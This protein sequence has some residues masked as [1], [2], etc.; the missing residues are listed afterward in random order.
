M[1]PGQRSRTD[2]V[3][4]MGDFGEQLAVLALKLPAL[5]VELGDRSLVH[6]CLS[7]ALHADRAA[8]DRLSGQ[9][10]SQVNVAYNAL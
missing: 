10:G 6:L 7:F 4:Q 5:S 2:L 8:N 1:H 9:H 3:G